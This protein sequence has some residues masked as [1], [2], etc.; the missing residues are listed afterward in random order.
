[1]GLRQKVMVIAQTEGQQAH[2][3]ADRSVT[4]D[5]FLVVLEY[6][7]EEGTRGQASRVPPRRR[8]IVGDGE[9]GASHSLRPNAGSF[10]HLRARRRRRGRRKYREKRQWEAAG[11]HDDTWIAND[12]TARTLPCPRGWQRAGTIEDVNGRG[13]SADQN[14][15]G[16]DSGPESFRV[17]NRS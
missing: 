7:V 4:V 17:A 14:G 9:E 5:V 8:G 3:H 13:D 11:T 12:T 2:R 1:M 15:R 6:A 16:H 10:V